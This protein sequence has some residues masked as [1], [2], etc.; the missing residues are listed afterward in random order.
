MTTML[1]A[2][3]QAQ[4][5]HAVIEIAKKRDMGIIVVT[6]ESNLMQRLCHRVIDFNKG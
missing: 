5:W 6:H 1:D 2:N 4:I 3:T